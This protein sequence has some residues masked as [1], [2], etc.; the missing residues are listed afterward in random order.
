MFD[1]AKDYMFGYISNT[2][3]AILLIFKIGT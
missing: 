2:A 1:T 3:G